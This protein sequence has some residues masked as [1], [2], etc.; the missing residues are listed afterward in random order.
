MAALHD[1][2]HILPMHNSPIQTQAWQHLQMVYKSCRATMLPQDRK[3][4]T[5]KP[6][7]RDWGKNPPEPGRPSLGCAK[8]V[9][10]F[11][12]TKVGHFWEIPKAC[13]IFGSCGWRSSRSSIPPRAAFGLTWG[14]LDPSRRLLN[15]RRCHRDPSQRVARTPKNIRPS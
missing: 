13:R 15:T 1:H 2:R 4:K 14:I 8:Q 10:H 5:V 6:I 7:F 12:Q 11:W 9:G 3:P